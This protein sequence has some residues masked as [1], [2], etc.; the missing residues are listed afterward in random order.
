[1]GHLIEQQTTIKD[2]QKI[3]TVDIYMDY[4]RSYNH[5]FTFIIPNGYTVEGLENFNNKVE[6]ATGGFVSSANIEGKALVVKTKKYYAKNYYPAADWPSITAFLNASVNFY[7]A[8][9]LLK[10]V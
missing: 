9:I 7:N 1:L 3:R 10:K 8:K 5:E 4:P 6:N 2:E